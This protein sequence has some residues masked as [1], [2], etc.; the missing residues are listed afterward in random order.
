[1]LYNSLPAVTIEGKESKQRDNEMNTDSV[2]QRQLAIPKRTTK[3]T[4]KDLITHKSLAYAEKDKVLR[5][6][7]LRHLAT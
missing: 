7:K 4:H 3:E 2:K 1:M 5:N 6:K